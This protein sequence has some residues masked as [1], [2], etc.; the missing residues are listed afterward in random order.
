MPGESLPASRREPRHIP[1]VPSGQR[2]PASARRARRLSGAS[3]THRS[4]GLAHSRT[5]RS[6]V[7]REARP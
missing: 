7:R 4:A 1:R 5:L 3:R 2:Q 6:A